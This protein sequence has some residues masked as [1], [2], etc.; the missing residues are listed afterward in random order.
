[1][2]EEKSLHHILKALE[3][4][5]FGIQEEPKKFSGFIMSYDEIECMPLDV[6]V[7]HSKAITPKFGRFSTEITFDLDGNDS[8]SQ[9]VIEDIQEFFTSKASSI[10][11]VIAPAKTKKNIKILKQSKVDGT[12]I[13]IL[14]QGFFPIRISLEGDV[15]GQDTWRIEGTCDYY[16]LI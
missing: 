11:G 9:K 5:S 13:T 12:P 16:E 7:K 14:I 1:M 10:R 3:R 4:E 15:I 6:Q 2:G 8:D